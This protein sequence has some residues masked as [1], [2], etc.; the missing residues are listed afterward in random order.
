MKTPLLW[1]MVSVTFLFFCY[2]HHSSCCAPPYSSLF[3][4]YST[5]LS[6]SLC[7]YVKVHVLPVD[8]S[9]PCPYY[10]CRPQEPRSLLSFN[11]G[12]HVPLAADGLALHSLQVSVCAVGMQTQEELLV[13]GGLIG[14]QDSKLETSAIAVE[15]KSRCIPAATHEM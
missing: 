1:F 12:F 13:S 7:S 8:P 6:L 3:F 5:S 10:C 2:T 11:E 4:L 15:L 9:R 14:S